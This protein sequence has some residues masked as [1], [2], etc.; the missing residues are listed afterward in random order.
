MKSAEIALS[1]NKRISVVDY[2]KG[3]SIFTIALMHLLQMMSNVPSK[4]IKLSAIGG[5]GVHVFFL[6]SGFGL[7]LSYLNKKTTYVEFLK[8]RFIKIYVPYIIVVLISF[9]V[10]WMYT[11]DDRIQALLSHV[12]LY[13][14]FIPQHEQSF[15]KHFWF[16]STIIQFY[17]VF[18]PLCLLKRKSKKNSIFALMFLLISVFWWVLCYKAGVTDIRVWNSFFLQYIW[19]F[20]LGMILAE[21]LNEGRRIRIN[22][23]VLAVLAVAGIGIQA[24]M[25][26][27]SETLK[28]FNDIPA[29]IGY[30]SLAL[31]LMMVPIIKKC[32]EWLSKISYEYFLIH[33]L[34]FTSILHFAPKDSLIIQGIFG[35]IG[36]AIAITVAFFYHKLVNEIT[37][38]TV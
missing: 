9:F 24:F 26:M 27:K 14:M 16:V 25:A 1:N 8:K 28:V 31:L 30:T 11:G 2:L 5:T 37:K 13:K 12:F 3:F 20:V 19:E 34:I 32:A 22:A 36:I 21:M 23:L 6:C 7:Y 35:V 10:P 38:R 15:G 18:I 4:I 17:I 33:I 29:L